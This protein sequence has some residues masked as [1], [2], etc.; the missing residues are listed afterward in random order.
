MIEKIET[1]IDLLEC[2]WCGKLFPPHSKY[3]R[4]CSPRCAAKY[5]SEMMKKNQEKNFPCPYEMGRLPE[6]ITKNQIDD[7]WAGYQPPLW[8]FPED[9]NL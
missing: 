9:K 7:T 3:S 5:R 8:N 2:A 1:D 6:E 4:F